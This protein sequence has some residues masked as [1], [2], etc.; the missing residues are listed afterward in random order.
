MHGFWVGVIVF[1]LLLGLFILLGYVLQ[2]FYP[3][4]KLISSWFSG[5]NENTTPVHSHC[6]QC[7]KCPVLMNGYVE[8]VNRAAQQV[9]LRSK[10]QKDYTIRSNIPMPTI[11]P[12]NSDDIS[13]SIAQKLIQTTATPLWLRGHWKTVVDTINEVV[14]NQIIP[15]QRDY[16]Q[17]SIIP[18]LMER[19]DTLVANSDCGITSY[20]DSWNPI[21]C[22]GADCTL[23]IQS[24]SGAP[25]R[26]LHVN[27]HVTINKLSSPTVNTNEY[28]NVTCN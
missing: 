10:E 7:S 9:Y 28:T 5:A 23:N 8:F 14:A 12:L 24:D 21:T 1:F 22:D 13:R 4:T 18:S 25:V 16:I 15:K 2:N 20:A 6:P 17:S 11:P 19:V 26:K 27:A 3:V